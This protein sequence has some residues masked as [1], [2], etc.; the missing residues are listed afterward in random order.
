MTENSKTSLSAL[1]RQL[2][3]RPTLSARAMLDAETL[4]RVTEGR[5]VPSERDEV[6]AALAQSAPHAELAHFLA[7]LEADS[8]ELARAGAR[9]DL[10]HVARRGAAAVAAGRRQRA[11]QWSAGLA[12][13]LVLGL[14]LWLGHPPQPGGANVAVAPSG[15]R[16][17]RIFSNTE[18]I[19]A[20]DDV[21][22]RYAEQPPAG[23]R[24]FDGD[25]SRRHKG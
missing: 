6:A 21:I 12:A 13:A 15:P 18:R 9:T 10:R 22:F 16:P 4:V 2:T 25:F 14:T 7:A 23:D 1:Y 24:I 5:V 20:T 11:L 3:A 8:A 17:D 19:A